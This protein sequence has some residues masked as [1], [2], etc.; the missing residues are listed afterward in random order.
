MSTDL[1]EFAE[2]EKAVEAKIQK[3]M[4]IQG[5]RS[6]DS[7]HKELGLIM[8]DFVGMG[9]TAEGLKTAIKKID[10]IK[11][12]FWSNVYIPGKADAL[13]NEL[14]KALRLADFIEIGRLMAVD[15]LHREESCG[16]H[17]REEYQT[18][19]GEALRQD[20]KFS[21]VGCWKYKGEDA[22]PELIKEPLDYEFTERKTRNYKA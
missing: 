1:P 16:G 22:E 20:D 10:E 19:D 12:E 14:E 13:N 15:A 21:Y 4:S 8:W 2:A 18:P 7:I 6:V 3:L 17:F 9:R 11:K 5:K